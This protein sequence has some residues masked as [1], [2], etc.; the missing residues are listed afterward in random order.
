MNRR[1]VMI[2]SGVASLALGVR[3]MA[4]TPADPSANI[5]TVRKF[6][7][8]FVNAQNPDA[9]YDVISPDYVSTNPGNAP[10]I[11]ALIAR[12]QSTWLSTSHEFS[13][14]VFNEEQ[15]IASGD[16]VAYRGKMKGTTAD[17]KLVDVDDVRWFRMQDGLILMIW[18]GPD[19]GTVSRQM[20]G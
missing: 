1:T 4:Q 10:G 7:A 16:D 20:Y 6:Y 13:S 2:G 12:N 19:S 15:I 5:K 11:E 8:D 18:G 17:G 9:A 3:A 14:L